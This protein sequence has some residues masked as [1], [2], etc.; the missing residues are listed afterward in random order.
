[1][2]FRQIAGHFG[3]QSKDEI[4]QFRFLRIERLVFQII[5]NLVGQTKLTSRLMG[6][7]QI[8]GFFSRE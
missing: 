6:G 7:L 3:F 5:E 1:M 8:A 2:G 4:S